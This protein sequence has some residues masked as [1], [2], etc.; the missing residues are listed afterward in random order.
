VAT[1]EE[2]HS[3]LIDRIAELAPRA[4]PV[5]ILRLAEALAWMTQPGQPHG[6]SPSA[7]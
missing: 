1:Y 4:N 7:A 3:A 2:A 5:T 6:S